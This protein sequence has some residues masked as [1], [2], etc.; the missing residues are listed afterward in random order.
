M[1]QLALTVVSHNTF[2]ICHSIDWVLGSEHL[3]VVY[4]YPVY[5]RVWACYMRICNGWWV[6]AYAHLAEW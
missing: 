3:A 1:Q 4:S 5:L 6:D 2:F